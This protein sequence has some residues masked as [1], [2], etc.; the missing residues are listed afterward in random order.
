MK[1]ADGQTRSVENY[2]EVIKELIVAGRVPRVRDIAKKAGVS[3][4]SVTEALRR[5]KKSGFVRHEKYGY[6]ELTPA[7]ERIAD[8][9]LRRHNALCAL[10]EG[11]LGVPAGE[12]EEDACRI[13]HVV[14]KETMDRMVAFVNFL[15]DNRRSAKNFAAKFADYY[16]GARREGGAS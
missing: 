14:S 4:A 9:M 6:V 15:K 8:E 5:M 3:M 13:E 10:L 2:L 11:H 16:E 7:G 1:K 12:A